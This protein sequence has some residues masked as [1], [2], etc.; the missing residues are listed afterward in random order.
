GSRQVCGGRAT[1]QEGPADT[2]ARARRRSP[3]DAQQHEQSRPDVRT[4]GEVCPGRAAVHRRGSTQ[5]KDPGGRESRDIEVGEQPGKPVLETRE[6]F[7]RGV[8]L[9]ASAGGAA[10]AARRG[11]SRYIDHD[12]Q[13]GSGVFGAGPTRPGGTTL[14]SGAGSA[15]AR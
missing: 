13:S 7:A 12:E 10:P 15:A 9:Y 1:L 2:P 6:I 5:A 4:P 11:P 3:G 8:S 14:R